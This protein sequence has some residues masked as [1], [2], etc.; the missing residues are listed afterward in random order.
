MFCTNQKVSPMCLR[1]ISH[2]CITIAFLILFATSACSA[3]TAIRKDATW[4]Q[5]DS[6]TILASFEAWLLESK[7]DDRA[8]KLVREYLSS[9]D[10]SSGDLI[11]HVIQGIEIGDADVA[12]FVQTLANAQPDDLIQTSGLLDNE[13]RHN[14]VR[15]HVRLLYGRWL[16]RKELFDESL[17]QL[18]Q[19][20]IED[21]LDPATLLYCR[22]LMQHQLL[23]PKECI[24]TLKQ[25]QENADQLPRRYNVLAKLMIADMKRL[26][27]DSLDEIS[28]MMGDIRRRTE[29]N[30]SGT[31]V[32]NKEEDV[33]EKLDKLIERL[34]EQQRQMQMAQSQG[35][36]QPTSPADREQRLS[37]QGSGEV[38]SKRQTDGG[39]WGDL[40]PAERDAALADMSKDLPPHYRSVIEEYFRKLADKTDKRE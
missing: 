11:D 21:V 27:A 30:R 17:L 24:V 15:N 22:G 14:F 6:V 26:E 40:D 8:A 3:Q 5:A 19:L 12:R 34:E 10:A 31:R 33:I 7:V 20:E 16:A 18:E 25:L 38:R 37:G 36:P 39:S 1:L 23:K 28:R 13:S 29:L 9:A 4:R 35:S 32:R 2:H